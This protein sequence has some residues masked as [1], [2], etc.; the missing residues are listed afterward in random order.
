MME[1]HIGTWYKENDPKHHQ[2]AELIIEGNNVEFYSRFHGEVL[3]CAFIG[4][5][6]QYNY[7]VFTNG[8]ASIGNNKILDYASSHKVFY[9]LMQNFEFSKGMDISGITEVSFFIPEIINWLG[10]KTVNYCSTQDSEMAAVEQKLEPILLHACDPAI[11]IDFESKTY[12]SILSLEEDTEITIKKQPRIKIV[13]QEAKNIEVVMRDIESVMQFFGLVIGRVSDAK[14]I[15]LSI[16]NQELKTWLYFNF[17]FSYNIKA[18]NFLGRPRTYYYILKDNLTDYYSSWRAFY[19][20]EKYG[21]IRRVYFSANNRKEIFA[22]DIFVQYIK[23]L[24]GYHLRISG[25]EKQA[26]TLE[27]AIKVS[28]K[29]IK[30]LIFTPEGKPIFEKVLNDALPGWTFKA[31][32]AKQ[33]SRWIA[34]GYLGKTALSDRLKNLDN[35]FFNII[36]NNSIEIEKRSRNK[37]KINGKS[38]EELTNMYFKELSTT[39]NYY[40]HFK[41]DASGILEYHQLN[42]SINVLKALI[43]SI[44]LSQMKIDKELIRKIMLWDEELRF[45]T[46]CIAK[47]GDLPFDPPNHN[48]NV[49]PKESLCQKIKRKVFRIIKE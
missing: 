43:L 23:I 28:E 33:V 34:T 10:F 26:E 15:R 45:E 42:D 37:E 2:S 12:E 16:E 39:R 40:S 14:D 20:D 17:D 46:M 11:E 24:E 35:Q 49:K 8:S 25:D 3:P 32:H 31:S 29:E 22:E 18:K 19:Y 7:K 36:A 47:E 13:Y 9:V 27:T 44:F 4:N 6:G 48:L 21:L 1:R 38:D 5:D 41:E 30:K